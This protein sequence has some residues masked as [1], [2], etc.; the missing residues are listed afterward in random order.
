MRGSVPR[1]RLILLPLVALLASA[2]GTT[3]E[4]TTT[5]GP[6]A[7]AGYVAV[8]ETFDGTLVAG[9]KNLH[10]FH[11]MPGVVTVTLVSLD[12]ATDAPLL[13]LAI[14]MWDGISCQAVL[15][16]GVAVPTTQ[17]I[18]T[19][20][21]DSN[22]CIRVWDPTTMAADSVLKYQVTAVHNEKPTS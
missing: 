1:V 11:T 6:S 13:G 21:I 22:V 14:G 20:S 10:T 3:T 5:T 17:L 12:P 8:T 18:G 4:S 7:T 15:E 9:G 16:T 2:C 19:A